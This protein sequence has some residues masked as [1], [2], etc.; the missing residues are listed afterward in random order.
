ME[1]LERERGKRVPYWGDALRT[2][3]GHCPG[4][5]MDGYLNFV[6]AADN[7]KEAGAAVSDYNL[8]HSICTEG[9]SQSILGGQGL[10]EL[11]SRL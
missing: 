5:A 8:S 10:Q 3:D 1:D 6:S 7:E 4:L 2:R 11:T 9:K